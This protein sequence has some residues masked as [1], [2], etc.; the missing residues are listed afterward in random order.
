M[1]QMDMATQAGIAAP[2]PKRCPLCGATVAPDAL[3]LYA[4]SCGWGGPG[5]PL[6]HDRG[7]AKLLA[8]TDRG[9]AD[10]Q[11]RRDLRRLADRGDAASSRNVFYLALLLLVATLIYL[12]IIAVIALCVW[13]LVD[14]VLTFSIIEAIIGFIFLALIALAL[15]PRRGPKSI[16]ATR[17]RFPALWAALDDASQRS[18][19]SLPA[20]AVLTADDDL[21]IV[22]RLAGGNTLTIG[23][24]SLPLL[25]D[26]EAKALLTHELAHASDGGTALHRYCFHAEQLLHELVY[27]VL[28]GITGQSYGAM[29]R[30]RRYARSGDVMS[31][32]GFMGLIVSWTFLLPFRLLWS[33]YHLLRMHESR[34]LEFAADHTAVVTYGPQAF[35]NGLSGYVVAR[36]T[37]VKSGASLGREMR[38]HNSQN[39]YAEMR[40]H[41][42]E[43]PPQVISQL[44]VE[45]TTGFRTLARSHPTLPDRLRA[46][47][48]TM[49]TLPPSP[50]PT[51][52]AYTL[53]TPAGATD[54]DA[55]ETELTA[56][57]F[58]PRTK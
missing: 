4:C 3:G 42:S 8:K 50:T 39:F 35:I 46:A 45:A 23:A 52:P 15:W 6:E 47:Y 11:A 43:L 28:E 32:V 57:L 26:V 2:Q 22:R 18:G 10:G 12:G 5:D 27:G 56:L 13:L 33:G 48:A 31:S 21:H 49:A 53:L 25:N 29:R 54:A 37:F 44:R 1:G 20:R 30:T 38:L 19:V 51:A 16:P 40:R 9:L 41:Y 58:T 7:L 17:E 55:I 34:M 24:A 14:A 36:R